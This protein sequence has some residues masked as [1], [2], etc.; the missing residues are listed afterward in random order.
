VEGFEQRSD[1]IILIALKGMIE[2]D[3]EAGK[4]SY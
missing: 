2:W 1:V 4:K 3:W